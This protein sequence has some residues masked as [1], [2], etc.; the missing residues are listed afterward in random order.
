MVKLNKGHRKHNSISLVLPY[1][2][3]LQI[4]CQIKANITD[5]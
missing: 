1:A 2:Q 5:K 4:W 3:L